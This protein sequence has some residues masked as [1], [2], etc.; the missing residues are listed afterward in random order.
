[1][2]HGT[3]LELAATGRADPAS[4]ISAMEAAIELSTRHRADA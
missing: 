1:V 3:A 2:D 4:L